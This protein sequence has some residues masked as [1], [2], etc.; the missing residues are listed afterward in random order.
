MNQQE[1]SDT[2]ADTSISPP[3]STNTAC[4]SFDVSVLRSTLMFTF[5]FTPTQYLR[6]KY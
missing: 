3:Q 1:P 5:L 2:I 6:S 4:P